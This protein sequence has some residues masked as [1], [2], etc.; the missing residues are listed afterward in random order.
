[1]KSVLR[2]L[3]TSFSDADIEDLFLEY[4]TNGD[5]VLSYDEF[6]D[7][8]CSAKDSVVEQ[9]GTTKREVR[10]S[11]ARH[12]VQGL[13]KVTWEDT[14][15]VPSRY[16]SRRATL[17]ETHRRAMSFAQLKDFGSFVQVVLKA[18]EVICPHLKVEEAKQVEQNDDSTYDEDGEEEEEENEE[19]EA[20]YESDESSDESEDSIEKEVSGILGQVTWSKANL[21]H[22]NELFVLKLTFADQ[23]SFVELV[24]EEPQDPSWFCSHW[25]GTPF[26]DTLEM[27]SFHTTVREISDDQCFW[28]CTFANNQHNLEELASEDLMQ[29]PFVKAIMLDHCVGT[30]ALLN[31]LAATPFTRIWCVLEDYIT[32]VHARQAK[33]QYHLFDVAS[34]VPEGAQTF[35]DEEIPRCAALLRDAGDGRFVGCCAHPNGWFPNTVALLGARVKLERAE[36]SNERDRRSILAHIGRQKKVVN[37]EVGKI[38]ASQALFSAAQDNDLACVQSIVDRKL[39]G[40]KRDLALHLS[41]EALAMAAGEGNADIVRLMLRSAA[42]P[43]VTD[44]CGR[45]P[46]WKATD[47]DCSEVVELLLDAR[48]DPR[49]SSLDP[50][51]GG[52]SSLDLAAEVDEETGELCRPLAAALLQDWAPE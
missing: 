31:E 37:K 34:I 40:S 11:A 24:A 42:D 26:K 51:D 14:V 3:D 8:L 20:E 16:S 5:G 21:Y 9:M 22:V 43:T 32:V 45:P 38:F 19:S 46:L 47:E 17:P 25:W 18:V 4:D 33:P 6:L 7:F 48:A 29:T 35:D 1:M 44:D 41:G 49:Q 39:L 23:C 15:P 13:G 12:R 28:I 52:A 10:R 30:V 36:A 50:G 2:L 27:L